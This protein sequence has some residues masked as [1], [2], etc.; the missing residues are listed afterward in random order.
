MSTSSDCR[1]IAPSPV[2]G[3]PR[4]EYSDVGHAGSLIQ[5]DAL[6]PDADAVLE[7]TQQDFAAPGMLQEIG[8]KLRRDQRHAAEIGRVKRQGLG[9]AHRAPADLGRVGLVLHGQREMHPTATARSSRW[10]PCPAPS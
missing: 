8:G 6:H 10:F 3:L 4:V 5:R 7:R 9:H 2:P 1:A